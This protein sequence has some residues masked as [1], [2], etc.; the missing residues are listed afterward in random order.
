MID[1]FVEENKNEELTV[2]FV[3]LGCIYSTTNKGLR[4]LCDNIVSLYAEYSKRINGD[5]KYFYLPVTTYNNLYSKKSELLFTASSSENISYA[6]KK[7]F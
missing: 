4:T 3:Q 5:I 2:F 1:I 6:V 7:V